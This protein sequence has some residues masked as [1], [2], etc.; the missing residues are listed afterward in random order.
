[1][2]AMSTL[3]HWLDFDLTLSIFDLKG[4]FEESVV[5]TEG[6][7]Q[8]CGYSCALVMELLQSCPKLLLFKGRL[9]VH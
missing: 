8:D 5:Y 2:T 4:I 6:L 1:M 3:H 7:V 9:T